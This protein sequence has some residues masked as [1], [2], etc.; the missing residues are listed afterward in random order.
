LSKPPS[1]ICGNPL[2]L[3]KNKA[4]SGLPDKRIEKG[5]GIEKMIC[6]QEAGGKR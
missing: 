5:E 1:S 4:D 2:R 6:G 3:R